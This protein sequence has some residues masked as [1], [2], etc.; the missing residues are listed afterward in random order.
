MYG[1]GGERENDVKISLR[2]AISGRKSWSKNQKQAKRN[3]A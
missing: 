2:R 1:V 3:L